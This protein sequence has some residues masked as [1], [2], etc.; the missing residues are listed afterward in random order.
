M[1]HKRTARLVYVATPYAG[2]RCHDSAREIIAIKLAKTECKK[3][4][5]AG[6]VPFSPILAWHGV[7]SEK[8]SREKALRAGLE[9]LSV[10]SYIYF[11]KHPDSEFSNGMKCEKEYAREIGIT[12]LDF[13]ESGGE[14]CLGL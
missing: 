4:I 9:A 5:E 10:C 14:P 6:Y 13:D 7:L 12:E 3:V 1:K 8:D 2:L 11:S